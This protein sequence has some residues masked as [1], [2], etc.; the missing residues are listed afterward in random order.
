MNIAK[1]FKCLHCGAVVECNENVCVSNCN[2]G[3]IKLSGTVIVEGSMGVD[4][5]DVSPKLL[6]G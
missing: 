3:K 5:V 4:Y 2:C 1:K 6:N